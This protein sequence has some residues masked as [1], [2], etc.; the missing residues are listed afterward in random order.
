MLLSRSLTCLKVRKRGIRGFPST[1][2]ILNL[3]IASVR[4]TQVEISPLPFSAEAIANKRE[5]IVREAT[6]WTRLR[7]PRVVQLYGASHVTTHQL[8]CEYSHLRS[9]SKYLSHT[10]EE[11]SRVDFWT[12]LLQACLGLQYLH[13]RGI[14]HNDLKCDNILVG[15]D[16]M[17]KLADFGLSSERFT[18][19]DVPSLPPAAVGAYH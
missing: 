8:V 6:I 4:S 1:M 9:L 10:R 11:M 18:A 19:S 16:G 5:Q 2:A 7:S 14:S 17:A 12:W 3:S 15:S 13:A